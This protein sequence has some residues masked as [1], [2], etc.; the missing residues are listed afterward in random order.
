MTITNQEIINYTTRMKEYYITLYFQDVK[1][2]NSF[3]GMSVVVIP[4]QTLLSYELRELR[5]VR[6]DVSKLV[7]QAA[8][9]KLKDLRKLMFDRQQVLYNANKRGKA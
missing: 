5:A 2:L 4:Q 1:I 8:F 6:N 9:D 3:F 7:G